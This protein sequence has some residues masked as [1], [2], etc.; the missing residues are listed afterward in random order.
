MVI[1]VGGSDMELILWRHADAE[2]PEGGDDGARRLTKR[3]RKDAA[4]MAGW[5]KPRLEGEWRVVVSPAQRTQQTVA[6]L[7][8]EFEVSDAIGTGT[9]PERLLREAGWP[10]APRNVLVVGHQPTLGEVAAQLL[11]GAEAGVSMRK[12]AVWWFSTRERGGKVETTL[13][14]MVNPDMVEE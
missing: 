3:G 5:L 2:D 7:D 10:T 4:K 13:K 12:G 6:P 1:S 11:G 14:A 8:A 9:S